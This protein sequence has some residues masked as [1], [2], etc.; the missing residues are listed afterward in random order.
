MIY[1]YQTQTG[2]EPHTDKV[3][4]EEVL[5]LGQPIAELTEGE[6]ESYGS[7]ARMIDGELFLGKTQ[8]EKDHEQA[9][10]VRSKRDRLIS[11][12]DWRYIRYNSEIRLGLDPSDNITELDAYI[13]ALRD[14][15]EQNGFPWDVDWPVNTLG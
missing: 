5:N 11:K 8:T 4:A 2:I 9:Q 3:F 7:L 15:P 10:E 14:I 13:Q 1:L 6:W 12:E